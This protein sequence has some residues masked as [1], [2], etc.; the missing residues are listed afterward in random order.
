M[1]DFVHRED[2]WSA[3]DAYEPYVGRWSRLVA[4][5]F[6][7][8]LAF[9]AGARWLD[10]GCGTGALSETILNRA[11]PHQVLGIDP[12]EAF[13]DFA[14]SRLSEPRIAFKIADAQALPVED[15]AFDVAVA[16][17]VLN[18]VADPA[19][20]LLEMRRVVRPGGSL[21]VYVW[22]YA[23]EMQLMRRFWEAA[24]TLDP[25]AR[26]LDEGRRFPICK[27]EPLRALFAEAGLDDIQDRAID[28]PT[29][30][31]DFDDYWSPFL[32]GQ[33]PA[34]GYCV[35]LSETK[36]QS[37]QEKLRAELPAGPDGSIRLTARAFAV[38][39]VR[40]A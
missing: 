1:T 9:P 20:A 16:G 6:L 26:E 23:G 32:G 24:V 40:P 35:S 21:A 34:P 29:V 19:R 27:P 31:R 36:R 25:A 22:D 3:G 10:V 18:F 2:K 8:W 37:L 33:G 17:L 5:E 30:F 38:R 39:G 7:D 12:S 28:V 14:R 13:L 4:A 15:E 11:A